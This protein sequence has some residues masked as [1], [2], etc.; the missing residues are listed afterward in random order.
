MDFKIG[1]F[2]PADSVTP[3]NAQFYVTP[4][5]PTAG[6]SSDYRIEI[7]NF[8]RNDITAGRKITI[9]FP[10]GF[11]LSG[12]DG[13]L[14]Y[15]DIDVLCD[16]QQ[17]QLASIPSA[18]EFG[19]TVEPT[20]ISIIAGGV[21]IKKESNLILSVGTN[22]TYGSTGDKQVLNPLSESHEYRV[23]ELNYDE[24]GGSMPVNM[25]SILFS[26]FDQKQNISSIDGLYYLSDDPGTHKQI[27]GENLGGTF[28]DVGTLQ[29]EEPSEKEFNYCGYWVQYFFEERGL[30]DVNQIKN[31]YYHAWWDTTSD[32]ATF[33]YLLNGLY[34]PNFKESFITDSTQS[35]TTVDN[36]NLTAHKQTLSPN[37]INGNAIYGFNIV[38]TGGAE[39]GEGDA[40][41]MRN[42][43]D[44]SSFIIVNLPEDDVLRARD[45]DG[46]G[47]DDYSELFDSYT[48]PEDQD[49]DNDGINDNIEHISGTNPN[50]ANKAPIF[51]Q[52]TL[53]KKI[54]GS[55]EVLLNEYG[56]D[57]PV[58]LGQSIAS[59]DD[60]DGD[61]KS[62]FA[63]SAPDA[64]VNGFF[65]AGTVSIYSSKDFS[66]I[67][68]FHGLAD[69][70][71]FGMNVSSITDQDNDGKKDLLVSQFPNKIFIVS[72]SLQKSPEESVLKTF[73]IGEITVALMNTTSQLISIPNID[74]LDIDGV[75]RDDIVFSSFGADGGSKGSIYFLSTDPNKESTSSLIKKIEDTAGDRLG[76][77]ISLID[78]RDGDGF[79]DI[80][81][82]SPSYALAGS[83][84]GKV[85]IISSSSSKQTLDDS[86]I[87]SIVGEDAI[88]DIGQSVSDISDFDGDG[89]R[90]ILTG[91]YRNIPGLGERGGVYTALI[92]SST[93][94]Q[95]LKEIQGDIIANYGIMTIDNMDDMDSDGKEEIIFGSVGIND[96]YSGKFGVLRIYTHEGEILRLYRGDS[97][98][99]YFTHTVNKL[100]DYDGDLISDLLISAPAYSGGG[101][102]VGAVFVSSTMV[103]PAVPPVGLNDISLASQTI[104][105]SKYF[106]DLNLNNKPLSDSLE[107]SVA[108]AL[109]IKYS[110][111][112]E[113]MA[114]TFN[115][116]SD[117]YGTETIRITATDSFGQK[118]YSNY[119][120]VTQYASGS[121]PM[122]DGD[123]DPDGDGNDNGGEG[124]TNNNSTA[125]PVPSAYS[126]S[127]TNNQTPPLARSNTN[128]S[129][130]GSSTSNSVN[131]NT[132]TETDSQASTSSTTTT[133]TEQKTERTIVE[134]FVTVS[135]EKFP[136]L[137][138][139]AGFLGS[140]FIILFF[141]W[142][143]RKKRTEAESSNINIQS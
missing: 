104:D 27:S 69:V 47:M 40:P 41:T 125:A 76:S 72:T 97:T 11:N 120:D 87:F 112:Q 1:N 43:P 90:D 124:D 108:G 119:F 57:N 107:F 101:N 81:A 114:I 67:K 105:L 80:L 58:N 137:L 143:R 54:T 117:W 85:R 110:I 35:I 18:S 52:N 10:E 37:E 98:S 68:S 83:T 56:D 4:L 66:V 92:Y 93:S 91:G 73:T 23:E 96:D 42:N 62:E 44:Q 84:V 60:M 61:G 122:N 16:G 138:V 2:F 59:I 6:E 123:G 15:T 45:S 25:K 75:G 100:G 50:E 8:S 21:T 89:K 29:K 140:V 36:F 121:I 70:D 12:T 38:M 130:S 126:P 49:T 102:L 106:S 113:A 26:I 127:S 20:R 24:A 131:Q 88:T 13:L 3:E 32:T 136:W 111:N 94:G 46:D 51:G 78:D 142:K 7:I 128:N 139:I 86:T 33:G 22:A 103:E 53:I 39:S 65:D 99:D 133:L 17:L 74:G 64:N 31:I 55:T 28:Y 14:D 135:E 30:F 79:Q 118:A 71:H 48:N 77:S 34:S 5:N 115:S 132:I 116:S 141:L 95:L 9:Q 82:G 63:I 129:T 19:I 134:N 109:N